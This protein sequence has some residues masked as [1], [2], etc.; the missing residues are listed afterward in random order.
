[1]SATESF[2]L[3]GNLPTEL[4]LTIWSEALSI[5]SVWAAVFD[6]DP[7]SPGTPPDLAGYDTDDLDP[8]QLAELRA[9]LETP[10]GPPP[11]AM[12]YVGPA[13][14][15]AGL[16]CG[17]SR[18]GA[19][20][21]DPENTIV[22]LGR[23]PHARATLDAL[24]ADKLRQIR[25]VALRPCR[26]WS[27]A[28]ACRRLAKE[29]PAL[30]TIIIHCDQLGVVDEP[31]VSEDLSPELAAYYAT[32][33]GSSIGVGDCSE[34]FDDVQLVWSL[35]PYFGDSPPT[36]HVVPSPSPARNAATDAIR[37]L[38]GL[39]EFSHARVAVAGEVALWRYLPQERRRRPEGVDSIINIDFII[40]IDSVPKTM[41]QKL[42]SLPGS[43][44]VQEARGFFYNHGGN[45]V[46]VEITAAWQSSHMPAGALE[47]GN[48]QGG[49]LPY[50]SRA[51][52][53]EYRNFYV[54]YGAEV[55]R[56]YAGAKDADLV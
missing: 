34:M 43:P 13:S 7:P 9:N 18:P 8:E 45:R 26:Y 11:P 3:F 14:Y 53:K 19:Y 17:E 33:P 20:W 16:A 49:N 47:I 42:L 31:A 37:I 2:T 1:M 41:K 27:I 32:I 54:K 30:Q 46:R 22:Y 21:V 12:A 5:R 35:E 6:K 10:V 56:G 23:A 36:F 39:T 24:G 25:H 52:L 48:V 40:D 44:F 28:Q 15:L 4:R 38:Q 50:L 51:D 29:C 55:T